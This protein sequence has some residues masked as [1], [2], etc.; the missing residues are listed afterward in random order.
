MRWDLL[1]NLPRDFN[2]IC[3]EIEESTISLVLESSSDPKE[4]IKVFFDTFIS[5]LRTDESLALVNSGN[6]RQ[7]GRGTFFKVINSKIIEELLTNSAILL[8]QKALLHFNFIEEDSII[9]VIAAKE[10][11]IVWMNNE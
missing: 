11:I 4:K 3:V 6:C 8:E 9:T 10:P 7:E 2:I 5:Y 1:L